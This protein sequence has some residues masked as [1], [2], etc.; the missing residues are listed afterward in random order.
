VPAVLIVFRLFGP[1]RTNGTLEVE[2]VAAGSL[3]VAVTGA[4]SGIGL[5]AAARLAAAGHRVYAIC[6]DRGRGEAALGRINST[7]RTPAALVLA[8][9]AEPASIQGAAGRLRDEVGHVDVLINNAAVFDQAA[10]KPRYTSAGHELFW[11]T[12]HLGPFQLTAELSP[13]L[14][15]A[16]R[17]RLITVASKGLVAM[18]RIRIRFDQLDSP[19]WYSPT[20]AYYHAKLAQIMMSFDLALRTVGKL[21][22]ACVRVPAV[23]LDA[24]RVAALPWILRVLYAPKARASAPPEQLA[25]TYAQIAT[26]EQ[27][28][29]DAAGSAGPASLRGIYLDENQRPVNAPRFAYDAA[30]RDR[31]WAVTELATGN[32]HWAW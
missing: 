5:R 30:A 12:N 11:A 31:L 25:H 7:A 14:A 21:D 8:D 26:R 18:P 16:P 32:P 17:P 3:I 15:A 24:D 28:W 13:L 22:V 2:L 23:R 9:L 10:R 29:T 19:E 27:D 6:R 1:I 4:N 20:R